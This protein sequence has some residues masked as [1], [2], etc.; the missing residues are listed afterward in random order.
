M[1]LL[2]DARSPESANHAPGSGLEP[3]ISA[4]SIFC[5][6]V[7]KEQPHLGFSLPAARGFRGFHRQME[8]YLCKTPQSPGL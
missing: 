8:L 5:G 6:A 4:V 2:G 3:H 7:Y 1:D